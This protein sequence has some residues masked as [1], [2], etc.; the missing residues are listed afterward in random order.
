MSTKY[1]RT[2]A[3][4]ESKDATVAQLSRAWL[5]TRQDYIVPIP[6]SRNARRVEENVAPLTS[7]ESKRS[8]PMAPTVPASWK[9]R[10]PAE[11]DPDRGPKRRQPGGVCHPRTL[12][13]G[14]A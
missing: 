7:P 5:L 6:G 13:P 9:L 14:T 11:T 3:L 1:R 10:T 12:T 8:C 4:A 2:R